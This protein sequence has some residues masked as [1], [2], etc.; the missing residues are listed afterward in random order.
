VWK[1][2]PYLPPLEIIERN[3]EEIAKELAEAAYEPK[4]GADGEP[5]SKVPCVR[6]GA[7]F[8]AMM[9][10]AAGQID[11]TWLERL[12]QAIDAFGRHGVYVFLDAHTDGWSTT[13]GGNGFPWWM[14]AEMQ[15]TAG[16]E[17]SYITSPEHPLEL[18][19]PDK[20]AEM[21]RKVG[22]NIPMINKVA[23]DTD[24]WRD[25]SVN[26]GTGNPRYMNLGNLNMRLNN[27]DGA[28]ANATLMLTKQVQNSY[29]RFLNSYSNGEDRER[30]F[31]PYIEFIRQL[32]LLWESHP[33]VVAVELLN[34]PPPSGLPCLKSARKS[35]T[36]VWMFYAHVLDE[37][38][39]LGVHPDAP[40]ALQDVSGSLPEAN[41]LFDTLFREPDAM[42]G[43]WETAMLHK[44][45]SK[46][47][48]V[49][50]FHFYPGF[51]TQ[52][53]LPEMIKLAHKEA[54]KFGQV[55][56]FLSEFWFSTPEEMAAAM[57][58]AADLDVDAVT[59][60]HYVDQ[61]Y[62]G[63]PGWYKYPQEIVDLGEPIGP[64]G[65]VNKAS[66]E[67]FHQTVLDGT[68]IG[69]DI[70]GAEGGQ[71]GVLNLIPATA[72]ASEQPKQKH[73]PN[74]VR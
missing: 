23:N 32:F 46:G 39:K 13:N 31:M 44:W 6:L 73:H 71:S 21:L 58:Q 10:D 64:N 19:I 40:V 57:A 3:A 11:T 20:L 41:H 50:S 15:R 53:E 24:P 12:S 49:L 9:P 62:T 16:A 22:A 52:V 34:E 37:L 30:F 68:F 1:A 60:W 28:W 26:S 51:A 35:R 2:A 14:G 67:L 70:D 18:A 63:N 43:K 61:I 74:I 66:W 47:K 42:C 27:N 36:A 56:V 72:A 55:P 33:N 17:T 38:D 5:R 29:L 8:E 48:L 4:P 59:Y 7:M 45:A 65:E 69:G 54:A 25:F